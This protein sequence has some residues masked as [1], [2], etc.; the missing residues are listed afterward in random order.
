MPSALETLVKI[1]KLEREQG[2][3][4]TAVIGGLATIG[5]RKIVLVGQEKGADTRDRLRRNFGMPHP[6]GYRKAIR[7][8]ELAGKFG[9]PLVTFID[10]PGA[11]AGV[12]AEERG[13]AGAIANCLPFYVIKYFGL[14]NRRNVKSRAIG[15]VSY[16]ID[17]L[18]THQLGFKHFLQLARPEVGTDQMIVR[19]D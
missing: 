14:T 2:Y 4:N 11:Y 5:G 12:G 10:T 1:L 8:F 15:E 6:E 7:L 18:H 9:L 17:I 13:Q 16:D 3:K 19:S